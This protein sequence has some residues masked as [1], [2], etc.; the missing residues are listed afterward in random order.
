[1]KCPNCQSPIVARQ[2]F[3]PHCGHGFPQE[4]QQDLA[5]YFKM[6]LDLQNLENTANQLQS[7][8]EVVQQTLTQM[9]GHID[10]KLQQHHTP[11][12]ES[13]KPIPQPKPQPEAQKPPPL[14]TA[15]TAEPSAAKKPGKPSK[16]KKS[17]FENIN[18]EMWLGQK[19]LLILGVILVIFSIAYF[20]KYSFDQGWVGPAGRVAMAYLA[21]VA[22]LVAGDQFRKR[23]LS[24]FGL[25]LSG[26]GIA[27]L[28]FATFAAF[29]LYALIGQTFAFVLMIVVTVLACLLA[30]IYDAKALAVLGLIGGFSTPILLS[31]GTDNQ[32]ALMTYM[33]F[34]NGGILFIAFF[35]QWKVLNNLGFL[36]TYLLFSVWMFESYADEK[37]T[38]T[39]IYL[40][41]FFL[42]YSFVPVAFHLFRQ[43]AD[44]KLNLWIMTPNT[45]ISFTYNYYLIS[46]QFSLPWISV[47][48]LTYAGIFAWMASFIYSRQHQTNQGI[49]VLLAKSILFLTLTI[50]LIF[51]EH[52]ITIFWAIQAGVFYWLALRIDHGRL[53]F[54]AHILLMLTLLSFLMDYSSTF[55]LH[56]DFYF[57]YGYTSHIVERYLTF[58]IV[59]CAIYAM[60][61]LARK[62]GKK[63]VYLFSVFGVVLFFVLN[64]EVS[65]FFYD[66]AR[67]ARF[68]AIS[69]LWGLFATTLMIMG[70]VKNTS[71]LRKVSLWLFGFT[72]I[73]VFFFDIARASTPFRILSF[74]IVGLLMVGASY[75]YHRFKDHILVELH[76]EESFQA[77]DTDTDKLADNSESPPENP[78]SQP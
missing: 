38:A 62:A 40:N 42:I 13:V 32:I 73:K 59:L 63:S 47:V 68:A 60:G 77:S 54:T 46:D 11:S 23:G 49:I 44:E 26:G 21:G 71:L 15:K 75:L 76:G 7:R 22:L 51:S 28:Y 41:I 27:A 19:S 16:P 33:V 37:F 5:L 2:A 20:L 9:D 65:A 48:T 1:M 39:I 66:Y 64:A 74:V 43:H 29:Q 31:T 14:P 53:Q 55:R 57:R 12:A 17:V 25:A 52:W 8:I 24:L 67:S 3:C 34:L 10:Q 69:V 30:V 18:W 78:S 4:I 6:K 70:F 61:W 58:S 56:D 72:L 45:L 36:F 50:P 35:K